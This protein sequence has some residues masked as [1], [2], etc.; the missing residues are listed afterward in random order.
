M[1]VDRMESK[2]SVGCD[3]ENAVEMLLMKT[4]TQFDRIEETEA[5]FFLDHS[6]SS[7]KSDQRKGGREQSYP[8]RP[9]RIRIF[10]RI[11]HRGISLGNLHYLYHCHFECRKKSWHAA[12]TSSQA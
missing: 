5:M 2:C 1:I 7:W 6:T 9:R 11:S 8:R 12:A 3:L 4:L 10:S